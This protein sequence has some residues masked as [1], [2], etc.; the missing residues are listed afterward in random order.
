LLIINKN[1]PHT[2]VHDRAGINQSAIM[3]GRWG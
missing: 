3:R 2:E 1:T